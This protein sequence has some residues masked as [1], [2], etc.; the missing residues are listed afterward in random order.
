MGKS[1]CRHRTI[2]AT[3]I[4]YNIL[5]H[6][7]VTLAFLLDNNVY[8]QGNEQLVVSYSML[9]ESARNTHLGNIIDDASLR[10]LYTSPDVVNSF[11]FGV[12]Q[13]DYRDNFQVDSNTADFSS[14]TPLDRES[15][16]ASQDQC[17]VSVDVAIVKPVN[18]F[19]VITVNIEILDKNDNTPTFP[20]PLYEINI[21]ESSQ[22]GAEFFIPAAKDDDSPKYN[23]KSYFLEPVS[24][25]FRLS[26]TVNSDQSKDL[27]LILSS[28]LDRE[29]VDTYN[30]VLKVVDGDTPP[31]T[32]SMQIRVNVVDHNDNS[33]VFNTDTYNVTV[34]ENYPAG[35]SIVVVH[36]TDSDAG[37]N[38]EIR[39]RLTEQTESN[40]GDTFEV[41]PI[42]GEIKLKTSLNYEQQDMY[43]LFVEATDLGIQ[44]TPA[45]AKV[46][47]HVQDVNDHQPVITVSGLSASGNIEIS[48]K[49]N[50]GDPV[51]YIKVEDLDRGIS[52]QVTCESLDTDMVLESARQHRYR[53]VTYRTF[54]YEVCVIRLYKLCTINKHDNVL[55]INVYISLHFLFG[56]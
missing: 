42:S 1:A 24:E 37:V 20:K 26:V 14:A 47:V 32:G 43:T 17:L 27:R 9:E 13:G 40:F 31:K 45:V 39:Y 49:A 21:S 29:S 38:G 4:Y 6:L 30:Q 7:L 5:P 22:P 50:V 33:P 2:T 18:Y 15:I 23:I 46:L 28:Q 54:D 48:E 52:G 51:A 56:L 19:R 16:C 34:A 25:Q 44:P 36:A 11:T 55:I 41:D 35:M 8:G 10:S 12:L 53:L 3:L